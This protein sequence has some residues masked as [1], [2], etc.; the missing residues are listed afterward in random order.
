[1][2]LLLVNAVYSTSCATTANNLDTAASA[3]VNSQYPN[4][5][6]PES[7]S[8]RVYGYCPF[9]VVYLMNLKYLGH[10]LLLVNAVYST[11][12]ATTAN[13]LDTAA[14]ACVNSQYPNL[15]V[16]ESSSARVYGYCP[17]HVVYPMNFDFFV[18][19]CSWLMQVV[20]HHTSALA[21]LISNVA[22]ALM[23]GVVYHASVHQQRITNPVISTEM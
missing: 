17:F 4:L 5:E 18:T 7:S 2:T 16:P 20:R 23:N 12:C 19:L 13:N 10:T 8:A 21:C 3:C 22:T 14:S 9:H 11:S 15:E 1:H 6:V